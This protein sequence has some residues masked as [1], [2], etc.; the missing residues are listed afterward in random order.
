MKKLGLCLAMGVAASLFVAPA[1]AN[2]IGFVNGGFE[3]GNFNGWT[4]SNSAYRGGIFNASLTPAWVFAN[5]G[6]AMHSAII[7]SSYVDP[8]V[9]AALLGTTVYS[10]KYAARIEDT[11]YGGY[12]SAISQTV[13]NYTEANI[14]FA[15]KAVLEGAHGPTD[16]AT[17][18]LVLHDDTTNTDLIVREYNAASGGGGV[19]PRFSFDGNNYYTP[20][21]QIEQLGIDSSLS[22]DSFTLSVLASDCE[23]TGHWGY[24]YLDGFGSVKPP[25]SVPEPSSLGLLGLGV[26]LCGGFA[27]RRR[28]EAG[29]DA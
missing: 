16:A 14:F 29:A 20:D 18:K 8:N 11:T 10:G 23:P 12:A 2:P 28:R 24:V 6:T 26:L 3:D 4:V 9:S 25:P 19:D 1:F 5:Q 17:M 7:D 22:G 13:T 21:W 27:W 15:W